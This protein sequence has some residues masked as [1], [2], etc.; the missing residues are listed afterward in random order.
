MVIHYTILAKNSEKLRKRCE[1][2][3]KF[4]E[5][6]IV[7]YSGLIFPQIFCLHTVPQPSFHL[8]IASLSLNLTLR[9]N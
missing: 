2:I 5:K 7:I 1:K 9:G 4:S 6:K 3:E 8:V